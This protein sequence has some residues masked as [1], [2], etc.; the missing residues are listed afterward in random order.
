MKIPHKEPVEDLLDVDRVSSTS[1]ASDHHGRSATEQYDFRS[2]R[3]P[4]AASS[5]SRWHRHS[6][7]SPARRPESRTE[8]VRNPVSD[9]PVAKGFLE[10]EMFLAMDSGVVQQKIDAI[11]TTEPVY[12]LPALWIQ[13]T[14][15]E[16]A[17]LKRV[18]R[19]SIRN[20]CSSR[21]CPRR[22]NGMPTKC[23]HREDVQLL[24]DKAAKEP[25]VPGRRGRRH[26]GARSR[27]ACCSECSGIC[28]RSGV[29]VRRVDGHSGGFGRERI[30]DQKCDRADQRSFENP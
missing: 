3:G 17:E 9:I 24:I 14:K 8:R 18:Y 27:P 22:S 23:S 15:K 6:S 5:P 11:K 10:P 21:T 26:R 20:P 28:L 30:E 25:A 16:A 7:G 12:G 19:D 1:R 13:A 4:A 2:H 29:P